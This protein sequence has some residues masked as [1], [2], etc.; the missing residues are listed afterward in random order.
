MNRKRDYLILIVVVGVIYLA[1]GC[2]DESKDTQNS[3]N[4][5]QV[6]QDLFPEGNFENDNSL[7]AW[8]IQSGNPVVSLDETVSYEGSRS[9]SVRN[10]SCTNL[11]MN[12]GVAVTS[13]QLYEISLFVMRTGNIIG[14]A[15]AF[16]VKASQA[17]ELIMTE[18]SSVV[19]QNVWEDQKFYFQPEND[20]PVKI[21]LIIGYENF[22]VDNLKLK[23]FNE[24]LI[25]NEDF[26][27]YNASDEIILSSGDPEISV[28]DTVSYESNRSLKITNE[29]CSNIRMKEYVSVVSD[30]VYEVSLALRRTG[31][32]VGCAGPFIAQVS[33]AG[34]LLTSE[35]I[36][37]AD[38]GLWELQNFNFQAQ[39][40]VPVKIIFILGYENIWIDSISVTIDKSI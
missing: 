14:C 22:W 32:V 36:N 9:L 3:N 19:D 4:S 7:T 27:H 39:N 33:Q 21:E 17:G 30:S 29:S 26:E 25:F 13:G 34:E 12:E 40:N 1:L 24:N 35:A 8:V 11:V 10:D 28:D 2:T 16:I 5:D 23:I 20:N 15:G 18:V 6:Q 38:E 31:N 37:I